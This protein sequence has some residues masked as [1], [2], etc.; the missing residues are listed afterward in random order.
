MKTNQDKTITFNFPSIG[1][2][3][4]ITPLFFAKLQERIGLDIKPLLAQWFRSRIEN[5]QKAQ[6]LGALT[7]QDQFDL[8]NYQVA[9]QILT[10]G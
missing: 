6:E 4:E 2:K 9:E 7:K 1:Y 5:L 3:F 10:S 8:K